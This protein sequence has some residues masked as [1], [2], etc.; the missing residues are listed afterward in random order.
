MK[1]NIS[2]LYVFRFFRDFIVIA[3]V[4]I[5]FY[6]A[7]GLSAT[8]I[9]LVQSVFSAS[10]LVFEIPSGYLSDLWGRKKTLLMGGVAIVCGFALYSVSSSILF[11]MMAEI[12]LGFGFSMCSGTESALLFDSLAAL[13]R[14]DD[15]RNIESR[16][17]FATRAGAAIS[18][19]AGGFLASF[20]IRLPFFANTVS[21]S[22][23]PLS[24]LF[25][26][27]PARERPKHESPLKGIL[28]AVVYSAGDRQIRSAALI[29]GAILTT[30]IIAIWGYFLLL[31]D[32]SFPLA[33]Y[34]LVFFIFQ[35]MSALG[36][37]FS[38]F[39]THRTGRKGAIALFAAIPLIYLFIGVF[40]FE[41]ILSLAFAQ[42]F[43]WGLSTPFLLDIINHRAKPELRATVLS[44]VSMGGRLLYVIAG[45]VFGIVVDRTGT[46]AGFLFLAMVFCICALL[47]ALLF[48]ASKKDKA[49]AV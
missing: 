29:S 21:A 43:L 20:H 39:L 4:I 34:G 24:A 10:M 31:E 41:L 13:D 38:H 25:M 19:I 6:K 42:A 5:P 1:N 14:K 23:L 11:F 8:Q 47:S 12:L 28:E 17:E 26:K 32:I 33:F 45:P 7:N 49:Q 9:L 15:Y 3:P 30:G 36:A 27:E 2:S 40:R 18:S 48:A 44:T 46:H 37:R 22:M 35:S 16:A